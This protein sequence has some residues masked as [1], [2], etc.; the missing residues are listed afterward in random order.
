MLTNAWLKQSHDDEVDGDGRLDALLDGRVEVLL[1]APDDHHAD[2]TQPER[3]Q[4]GVGDVDEQV[5][6]RLQLTHKQVTV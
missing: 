3:V 1:R 4:V 5:T 6:V 2:D